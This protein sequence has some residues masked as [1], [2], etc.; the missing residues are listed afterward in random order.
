MRKV[1]FLAVA[2][3]LSGCSVGPDYHQ[4]PVPM[5]AA[6]KEQGGWKVAEPNEIV[7]RGPWWEIYGDPVLN[8]LERKA[9]V[10]NQNIKAA[11]A[12]YRQARGI[13]Q[14]A[15]A[16]FFPTITGNASWTRSHRGTE[17]ETGTTARGTGKPTNQ[18][19]LAADA[20]W[21][22]DIWGRIRRT[23]EASGDSAQA[24]AADLANATLSY[25]AQLATTYFELRVQ[26][27]LK[28]LL[29]DTVV[30]YTEALQITQNKYKAGVVSKADV[31]QAQT[32]LK[33]T[34]ASA[35]NAAMVR[36]QL[37]HAIAVLTG[38]PPANVTVTPIRF[39][40]QTP[41]IPADVPSSLLE[42][43]PDVAAA[44]R[45]AAAA[46]AQ[47][48]VAIA[49][50]FPDLTL[51]GAYG[52]TSS[53]LDTLLDA[54]SRVWSFGPQLAMTLFDAGATSARVRQ[55]RATYDQEV[56]LYRQSVLTALQQVED[57]LVALDSLSREAAF[58][59]DAVNAA[60]EAEKIVRNQYKAGTVAFTDVITAQAVALNTRQSALTVRRSQLVASV[61]LIQALGGGWSKDQMLSRGDIIDGQNPLPATSQ[62]VSR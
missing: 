34:Q 35:E 40:V 33:N 6:Y 8:G 1:T 52:G 18:F 13:L 57:Q 61:S 23:V 59:N 10:S 21:D 41:D 17:S 15:R 16:S 20:S 50:Y 36:S 58:Q 24:S 53:S 38:E 30:A 37:E 32:Q 5:S 4:P 3:V 54:S 48:G 12:A 27:E 7:D 44:E 55:A 49:A 22:I 31:A 11:E 46:N 2:A 14:E 56:A 9:I 47:I 45:R 19:V 39:N 60:T 26:D 25:Q 43:R 62:S 29:D 42:R 51:S 28:Y